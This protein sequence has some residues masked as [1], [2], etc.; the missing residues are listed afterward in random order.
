MKSLMLFFTLL[1]AVTLVPQVNGQKVPAGKEGK[2]PETKKADPEASRLLAEARQNR[3]LWKDFFGFSADIE[4]NIDG[5]ISRGSVTIDSKGNIK[6]DKLDKPAE[7]W[8]RQVLTTDVDH[9]L[10]A[11]TGETA[12]FFTDT[13][14]TN[15]LGRAVTLIGDGMGSVY[16]VRD[17]QIVVVNRSVDKMRFAITVLH[18]TLNGEG[19]YLPGS[20]IVHYWDAE[21][22]DLRK[23]DA[24]TQ[25]WKRIGHF[26]LPLTT[27]IVS[28]SRQ[29]SVR[30][31]TLSNHLLVKRSH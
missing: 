14:L 19:K 5:T 18:S 12:C 29:V 4:V 7:R 6:L 16:R 31:M 17:K 2:T 13:D 26:D 20:F 28:S 27:R 30:S 24:Y 21:S 10:S 3:A 23:T 8:A 15:P 22:G 25:T 9:R 1:L 11:E